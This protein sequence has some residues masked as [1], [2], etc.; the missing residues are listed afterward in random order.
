ML[1]ALYAEGAYD[2]TRMG[3]MSNERDKAVQNA[4]LKRELLELKEKKL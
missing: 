1:R 4:Q 2:N 3:L